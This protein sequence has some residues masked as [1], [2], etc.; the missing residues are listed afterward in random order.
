MLTSQR[1]QLILE[2]LEAEGQVQ[3][4]ALSLIFSVSE[5]TIRRDLRELAAEGRLQRVHGGALPA[6]SAIAPFAERQSVK[7][8]A[9]KRV[10]RRGAQFISPGQVVIID[11]GTTTSE[12]ITFLPPDLRVTVVTHSPGIALGLV[13]HPCIEV[14][15]IG[16]RLYK[17]SIVTVGAAAIEDINNIHAD[18]FFMGVTGVH[19]ESGLTTGDYEEA[20]IK[21]AFSGRA[22]ETVVLASPE[23]INTASAFVIGDLSLVNTLVVE[24]TTD[25]RWVNAMKEKGVAVIASQ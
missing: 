9:K 11:G 22:A 18:L 3:S 25:E 19:P 5:D 4:T 14:I 16:G 21:R 12:L 13:N 7:M 6:S 20:C 15:L 24:N 17:H 10:A 1:K 8:D 2:K 23:K